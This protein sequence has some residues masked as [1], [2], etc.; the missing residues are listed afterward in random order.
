MAE[1]TAEIFKGVEVNLYLLVSGV[2]QIVG[3]ATDTTITVNSEIQETTTKNTLSGKTFDY[4]GKYSYKLDCKGLTNLVDISNIV[5]FQNAMMQQRKLLFLFT[6]NNFIQYSGT[7]L[8]TDTSTDSPVKAVSQSTYSFQ[9]DGDL[10]VVTTDIPP[11]PPIT[12]SVQIID[13]FGTVIA[14]VPAPGTYGVLR[15]DTIDNGGAANRTPELVIM[16]AS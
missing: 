8:V 10:T 9:G 13:Q 12:G 6:D 5:L 4:T 14:V 1:L 3:R 11:V 15:F 7:V 2:Y 16:P